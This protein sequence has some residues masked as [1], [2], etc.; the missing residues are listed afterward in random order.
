MI[1][2][3]YALA[4]G[5]HFSSY[6][7]FYGSLFFGTVYVT[8]LRELYTR[9][10]GRLL[11]QAG[12]RRRALLVGSGKHIEAVAHALGGGPRTRVE[13]VGYMS[14]TPRPENGLRSL[15]ALDQLDEVLATER[16]QEVIIADPDFPQ[17]Q[18][19]ELVDSCHRRGVDRR[20]SR[21]RRWRS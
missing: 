5:N 11:D 17:E 14:L 12:Y 7:I 19:L 8:W 10:T 1:A 18:A 20:T 2:L 15:G 21:R 3:V 13:L 16:V 4:T 9:I 6:Y